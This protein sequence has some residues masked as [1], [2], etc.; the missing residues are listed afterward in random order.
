MI[1]VKPNH[2]NCHPETC[3][4]AEYAAFDGDTKLFTGTLEGVRAA[5]D[6]IQKPLADALREIAWSRPPG[7]A[8]N[9]IERIERK[10]LDV[11]AEN[12]IAAF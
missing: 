4:C 3:C 11:L 7:K 9:E 2:C 10:A 6:A 12:G 8:P 1:E 5:I